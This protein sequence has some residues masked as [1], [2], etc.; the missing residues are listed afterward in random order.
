MF[1]EFL[2][3]I[4]KSRTFLKDHSNQ[5]GMSR[6][7]YSGRGGGPGPG[8]HRGGHGGGGYG[9]QQQGGY[10]QQQYDKPNYGAW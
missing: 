9:N 10:N 2:E 3:N 8:G 5:Y 7:G 6:G 4:L 1:V